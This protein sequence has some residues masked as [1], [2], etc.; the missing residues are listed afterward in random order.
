[1][2]MGK[3][4]GKKQMIAETFNEYFLSVAKNRKEVRKQNNINPSTFPK[5]T[6]N[7]YLLQTFL[8][9]FPSMEFNS[10]STN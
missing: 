6:P 9:P 3:R 8:N 2:L 1:M 4:L 7:Y 5:I 10:L